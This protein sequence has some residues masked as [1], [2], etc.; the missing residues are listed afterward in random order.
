M[1]FVVKD[2]REIV[3]LSAPGKAD[4]LTLTGKFRPVRRVLDLTDAQAVLFCDALVAACEAGVLFPPEG[5]LKADEPAG[6]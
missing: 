2:N 5:F 6:E 3:K 4:G 1:R